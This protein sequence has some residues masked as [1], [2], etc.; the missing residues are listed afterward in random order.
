MGGNT[1]GRQQT[2]SYSTITTEVDW[3]HIKFQSKAGQREKHC[4]AGNSR[5]A[6]KT[7]GDHPDIWKGD[8]DNHIRI[9]FSPEMVQTGPGS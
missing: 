5:M 9:F 8:D 7:A 1:L 6:I 4:L 2:N 3:G